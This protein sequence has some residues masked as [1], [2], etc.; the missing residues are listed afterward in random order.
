M[1][2]VRFR[3]STATV[4]AVALALLAA[5]GAAA[6][7][8]PTPAADCRAWL[9]AM[10]EEVRA[11]GVADPVTARIDGFPYLR[12]DRLLESFGAQ[13]LG[14]AEFA[15]WV[16]RLGQLDQQARRA[17]LLNL[18]AAARGRLAARTPRRNDT[19]DWL[20]G[21]AAQ[22]RERLVAE[23]FAAHGARLALRESAR[24]PDDYLGW[25]RVLGL[26]PLTSVAFRVG[27]GAWHA[28]VA[29]EYAQPLDQLPVRGRLITYRPHP[30]RTLT[31]AQVAAILSRS[32]SNALGLPEP[33]HDDAR[34]L[35]EAFAPMW[36]VDTVTDDDRIGDPVVRR[37]PWPAIDPR[38]P[39]IYAYLSHTRPGAG[40][41]LQLNYVA[42]FPARPL[43]SETDL[44]GGPID[45]ITWRVTLAADGTALIADTMHNCGCYH[46]FYP[47]AR[48]APRDRSGEW[49]EEAFVPQ[50]LPA[51][52]AGERYALR[53]EAGT[54]YVQRVVALNPAVEAVTYKLDDYDRLRAIP[55]AGGGH[56]SLFRPDGIVP[57]SERGERVFFWPMG[58]PEPGAMRARGRHATA[59]VGRRHFDDPFLF[60]R[61]FIAAP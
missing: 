33:R 38:I 24:V 30:E 25:Q 17:E 19:V 3:R 35:L 46:L 23:D 1:P 11:A 39:V 31:P 59:F 2:S 47:S 57:G 21:H 34:A 9:A 20:L 14:A 52:G 27:I 12:V 45:G 4:F 26:Y 56:R 44:L 48:L 43:A 41:L 32:R 13:P 49:V 16:E 18:D 51:L 42:W 61:A 10:D 29:A 53:V 40:T 60:E 54:H 8:G 6:R 22:C 36:I 5:A 15:A 50:R 7:T 58:V 55:L 28:E 37:H